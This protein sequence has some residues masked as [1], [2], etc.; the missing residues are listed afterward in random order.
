VKWYALSAK[1][2]AGELG[3][4][5][6][7]S[8]GWQQWNPVEVDPTKPAAACVWLWARQGSLCDAPRTLGRSFDASRT[9][10]QISLRRQAFCKVPGYG[11]VSTA[12]LTRL[13]AASGDRNTALSLLFERLIEQHYAAASRSATL[14]AEREVVS[15]SFGGSRAGYL[16][17]LAQ[18]HL[19]V[20]AARTVL[21]DEIR[22][23]ELEQ[24]QGIAAPKPAEISRFYQTYPQLLVRRVRVSPAAPWLG[25]A[26]RGYAVSGTAPASVFALPSGRT[27]RIETLLGAYRVRPV[28]AP[29]ALGSLPIGTVRSAIASALESYGRARAFERWTIGEQRRQLGVAICRGDELPEPAATD[30]AQYVPFLAVR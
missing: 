10:G 5:S 18:A 14:A 1:E 6:V 24:R 19:S 8:W 22:R 17:A 3:L 12:A 2:V 21:G 20:A 23:A 16:A 28:G 7:F 15:E 27:S 4:G 29:V 25:G 13:T 26:G 11:T 30:F 9:A